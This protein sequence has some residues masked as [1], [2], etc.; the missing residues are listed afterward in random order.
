VERLENEVA[1]QEEAHTTLEAKLA[2]P[3]LYAQREAFAEATRAFD[4]SQ[5]ELKRLM[6]RWERAA[7]RLE[8][9]EA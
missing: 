5:A 4:G 7:A 3:T 1:R 8:A 2:D 6:K 9:L